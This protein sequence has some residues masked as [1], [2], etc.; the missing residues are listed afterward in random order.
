VRLRA[1]LAERLDLVLENVALRHQLMVCERS[2]GRRAARMFSGRDRLFW[3]L[4][5]RWWPRWREALL[6]LQPQTV[7]RW[8]R[9]PW[10]RHLLQRCG[11]RGGRPR[12]EAEFQTLIRRMQAENPRWGS[13]RIL[14]ELKKLRFE[15]SNSSV[16]RYRASAWSPHPSQ[17]WSTFFNNHAPYLRDALRDELDQ[18]GRRIVRMLIR[19]LGMSGNRRRRSAGAE[20]RVEIRGREPDFV[21][22]AHDGRRSRNA[23]HALR[24]NL[25][26]DGPELRSEAA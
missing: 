12:I 8:Q 7:G 26:R 19:R 24:V 15:V 14:G 11:R 20:F 9:T 5:A 13:M 16:R 17:R 25:S 6:L 2:H 4:L 1:R 18:R 21:G 3:V 22:H 23:G 10:W